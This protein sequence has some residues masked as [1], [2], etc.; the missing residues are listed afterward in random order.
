MSLDADGLFALL[1]AAYRTRD[2][3]NGSPLQALFGVLAAQSGIVEEN[4]EQLYDDQF[5]ETCEQWVIP[6]IGDLLGYNS[7]YEVASAAFDS[8]TEVANTIGYRR[9]KGTLIAL[10]QV[11]MDVSGRAALAVEEFKRLI[12]TESMRKVR[13]WHDATVSLRNGRALDLIGSAFDVENRTIDVR[14]IA[15]RLRVISDPD[16]APLDIGLHGPG[17]FNI[18]DIAIHLWRC[19][20]WFVQ[21][22]PALSLGGGRYMF[23]PLGQDM[24]LFL[25]P[26][27]RTSFS[28][29]TTAMDVPRPIGRCELAETLAP[30]YGGSAAFYGPSGSISL[31]VDGVPVLAAQVRSVNLGDRPD[32]SLC[33]VPSGCIAIDPELGRIQFASDFPTPQSLRVYYNYGFPAASGGGPYD[34]SSSLA[35]I[36]PEQVDF[37]AL[38]G[39]SD[40]P[41][42]ESAVAAWNQLPSGSSGLIVLPRFESYAIDVTGTNAITLAPESNLCIAAAAPI[43]GS[44]ARD[45][46]WKESRVVLTGNIEVVGLS[47]PALAGD[48]PPPAGQLLVSGV[49]IAG[50]LLAAGQPAT[51]DL[52]D[53]TLVPGL[54]LLRNGDPTFPGDASIVVTAVGASLAL[55]R[56]VC[57][58]IAADASGSTR[59]IASVIDATASTLVAYGGPDLASAGADLQVEDS[60]IVG[61]VRTRTI[62]LASNTIFCAS[63]A[64]NDPWEAAVWASRRQSGCVRFCFV[65][66]ASIT[67]KRYNCLPVDAAS[68][69]ALEP[70]FVTTRYGEPGYAL[71]S[72]YVPMAIWHGADNGSQMGAYL[73]IQETEA[74]NNVQLRAPEYLPTCLESGIFLHPSRPAPLPLPIQAGY[75]SSPWDDDGEE[76]RGRGIGFDLL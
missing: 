18:P 75:G 72:G 22:A 15:P 48:E 52:F 62:T 5:I 41:T 47:G 26:P 64:A 27:R 24:P 73:Q 13:P 6:Y 28:S 50:Q 29:L 57:G 11:S 35:Q 30:D 39:S 4:I 8:R 61:K 49:W 76:E 32:G 51:I 63:L 14:R 23:S 46:I 44:S 31:V 68:E 19:Q 17:R 43:A 67:P 74:V 65:P 12:T 54:G 66:F 9:R 25:N 10:E 53:C 3:V 1:P 45:V 2:L 55:T 60:T 59:V 58:P 33:A 42:L 36:D 34:R 21:D 16:A 69:G 38:V 20:P 37:F 56:V 70:Q 7:I 71:L 40:F